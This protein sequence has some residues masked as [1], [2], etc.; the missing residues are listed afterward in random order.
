MSTYNSSG[1]LPKERKCLD[2]WMGAWL[3]CA[4]VCAAGEC[5]SA[6]EMRSQMEKYAERKLEGESGA[7]RSHRT[8]Y[9]SSSL[10]WSLYVA[11]MI[12]MWMLNTQ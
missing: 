11:M 8:W 4:C 12:A 10:L 1:E 9:L 2:A 7:Y 6:D 5:K 3:V